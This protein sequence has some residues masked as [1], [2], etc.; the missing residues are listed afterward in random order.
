MTDGATF[1]MLSDDAQRPWSVDEVARELGDPIK[2]VDR[3]ARLYGAVLIHRCGEFVWASRAALVADAIALYS[4]CARHVAGLGGGG[5][6]GDLAKRRQLPACIT[7]GTVQSAPYA[8]CMSVGWLILAESVDL[9][10]KVTVATPSDNTGLFILIG[11]LA[12]V[13]GSIFVARLAANTA[14]TRQEATITSSDKQHKESLKAQEKQHTE[15]LNAEDRR[16][17]Q[18]LQ[19]ERKQQE[20]QDLRDFFDSVAGTYEEARANLRAFGTAKHTGAAN[21]REAA[22]LAFESSV[23][24]EV[25]CTRIGLRFG[26]DTAVY[27][28]YFAVDRLVDRRLMFLLATTAPFT[29][30]QFSENTEF[31]EKAISAFRAFS[32]AARA[33]IAGAVAAARD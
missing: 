31:G 28:A 21:E 17:V 13:G 20:V 3:V 33:E 15:S 22:D 6:A 7:Y 29:E 26:E 11:A 16:L 9:G 12:T 14:G 32:T 10:G 8:L 18:R 19:H 5:T 24:S 25:A 27:Q 1:D 30:Q 2:T 23:R 4:R